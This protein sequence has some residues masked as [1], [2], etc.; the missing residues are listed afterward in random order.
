MTQSLAGN[1]RLLLCRGVSANICAAISYQP[2][3]FRLVRYV[4]ME[5]VL[6]GRFCAHMPCVQR[7]ILPK[8]G[9]E[10]AWS[11]KVSGMCTRKSHR[12]LIPRSHAV[13]TSR[14]RACPGGNWRKRGRARVG[15]A[16]FPPADRRGIPPPPAPTMYPGRQAAVIQ[17]LAGNPRLLLRRGI[18]TNAYA[19]ISYRPAYSAQRVRANRTRCQPPARRTRAKGPRGQGGKSPNCPAGPGQN[20]RRPPRWR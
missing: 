1:P 4:Y 12:R 16:P 6:G 18:T 2:A 3:C 5:S 14:R 20:H 11:R 10:W 19:A 13:C 9:L 17:S 7:G 8:K 15:A